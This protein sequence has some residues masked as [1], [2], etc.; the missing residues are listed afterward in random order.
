MLFYAWR[1]ED[2]G[3]AHAA[4]DSELRY[5]SLS[6]LSL[7]SVFVAGASASR[8]PRNRFAVLE[9]SFPTGLEVPAGRWLAVLTA[10]SAGLLA[11]MAVAFVRGPVS[12]FLE[13][14]PVFLAESLIVLGFTT[15]AAW[16]LVQRLG[17]SR[18]AYPL[19]AAGWMFF[20]FGAVM[21]NATDIRFR[22]GGLINLLRWAFNPY[23][24]V[25]GRLM[26]GR[27]MLW[28]DLFYLGLAVFFLGLVAWRHLAE[29]TRHFPVRTAAVTAA[30]L[31]LAMVSGTLY[32]IEWGP[33]PTYVVGPDGR[34]TPAPEPVVAEAYD[35]SAYLYDLSRPRFE[36][37]L[38]LIN[39]SDQ[40]VNRLALTL[41]QALRI[42]ELSVPSKREG[43]QIILVLQEPQIRRHDRD[44]L[45]PPFRRPA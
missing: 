16:W 23:E 9:E 34:E 30:S 36:A 15:G 33:Q 24:E 21:M 7:L 26:Y 43:D 5:L 1:N 8:S 35:V 42:T 41:N 29:R 2:P 28:Q 10:V 3:T 37:R 38:T 13:G 4:L 32:V 18:L 45:V 17:K 19:L 44:A 20:F 25:W 27:L 31:A 40:P 22:G 11:P 14:L 6:L 12:S 39:R